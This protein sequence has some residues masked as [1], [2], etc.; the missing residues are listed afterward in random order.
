MITKEGIIACF[1]SMTSKRY[2]RL[3][4]GFAH[5]DG[6][7][8]A[9]F[10]DLEK[11]GWKR[12]VIE[13]WF[14]WKRTVDVGRIDEVMKRDGISF[15]RKGDE[16]YPPLLAEIADP[17]AY[18]FMR[19]KIDLQRVGV[20][21]VGTRKCT[22]YGQQVTQEIVGE[23]ARHGVTIVS[24]LAT[25]IDAYA[26]EAALSA[27]GHTVAVLGGGVDDGT[28][29]P[30][31]NAGLA[32]RILAA[33]GA[34]VSEYAPWRE[35]S[36]YTFPARNRIVAGM[37]VMTLV[38]E[39]PEKSGAL[40]TASCALDYNREVGAVPQNVTSLTAVGPNRLIGQGA[41]V[42]TCGEDV[43]HLLDLPAKA[44]QAQAKRILPTTDTEAKILAELTREG[45]HVDMV[46]KATCL[47]SPMVA[48]TLAMMEMKGMVKNIGSMTY[49]RVS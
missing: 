1:G 18:L 27:D 17:P 11:V 48:S 45:K 40:I 42:V 46:T 41:H 12:D 13:T 5:E 32:K 47:P 6:A 30:R 26:H 21:V 49:I 31:A 23:L 2:E 33:G 29:A 15:V 16:Y 10:A 28:I 4:R 9:S 20:A 38:I 19:G 35:P 3:M 36:V 7:W 43:L 34:V 37:S 25:G 14:A 44:Q 24:G 39:A 22:R 8:E